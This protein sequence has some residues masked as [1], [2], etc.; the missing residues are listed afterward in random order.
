MHLQALVTALSQSYGKHCR[1]WRGLA[2]L[3]FILPVIY[4]LSLAQNVRAAEPESQA[5]HS[6][7]PGRVWVL[8]LQG[9]I[10][11]ATADLFIRS[12]KNAQT[13]NAALF[14]LRLDTPGGLDSSMRE[15]IQSVLASSIPVVVYVWPQGARAA[16][17]GTYILYSAHIAAMAPATNLGA[18]TPVQIGGNPSPTP[19]KEA[20]AQPNE[21]ETTKGSGS[22][23]E[24]KQISDAIAY[25]RGLAELRQRNA[26]WAESAVRTAASLSASEALNKNVIDLIAQDTNDLLK[27]MNGR[28]VRIHHHTVTLEMSNPT[29]HQVTLDWR[30]RLLALITDPNVAYFL[31]M[32]GFYGLLLEFYSPGM[33]G[34]GIIGGISLVVGMYA[35]HM[36]PISYAGL[37]LIVLGVGLITAEALSPSFGVM[38]VGGVAALVVGSIMLMDTELPAFQI[39]LPLISAIALISVLVLYLLLHMALKSRKNKVVSGVETLIGQTAVATEDFQ[40]HGYVRAQGELWHAR[41]NKA[42]HKGDVLIIRAIDGL[43]LSVETKA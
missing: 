24:R 16:S 23:M 43:T 35:L 15:M 10:G 42:V 28:T 19:E 14:L 1:L 39:A 40:E 38:G 9:A 29:L 22:A 3:A 11:P 34:P 7:K 4:S 36:L 41:S 32:I 2:L 26:D 5:T 37:A 30:H 8:D 12:L 13:E 33:G 31:I 18:A 20:P 25:I 17:A 27:Q 21:P 6:E